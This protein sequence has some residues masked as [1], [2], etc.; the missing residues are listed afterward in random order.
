MGR[1]GDLGSLSH[2]SIIKITVRILLLIVHV[3]NTFKLLLNTKNRHELVDFIIGHYDRY[4]LNSMYDN[5][6]IIYV[7]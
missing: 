7:Y 2:Y 5:T 4:E 1:K 3:P 6:F